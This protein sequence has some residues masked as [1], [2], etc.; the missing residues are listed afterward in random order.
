MIPPDMG[1][2][3]GPN[4]VMLALNSQVRIQDKIG[5]SQHT[6][7][8]N[9]FFRRDGQNYNVFDPKVIFDPYGNR[10]IITAPANSNSDSSVLLIGVSENS[11]PYSSWHINAYKVDPTNKNWFD[12]PS[13]GFNK[14]WIVVTGNIYDIKQEKVPNNFIGPQVYIFDKEALYK[15]TAVPSVA[16]Y[17][18]TFGFTI[19]PAVTYDTVLN[20]MYLISSFNGSEN[21][22]GFLHIYTISGTPSNPGPLLGS[23]Y[24]TSSKTWAEIDDNNESN[25]APQKDT[26]AKIQTGDD[27]I[28][29]A[30]YRNGS[31]WCAHTIFLPTDAPT[32]SGIQWW[33]IN[34]TN[35]NSLQTG[36]IEDTTSQTF[37]AFPSIA[38]DNSNNVL[39]G[40][41]TFS[42]LQY[43]SSAFS[44]HLVTDP[45]NI[46]SQF[47]IF[48]QGIAKYV[49]DFGYGSN[50]WGDYSST[51]LDPD[52]KS[53]WTIQEYA[54]KPNSAECLWGTEWCKV[55]LK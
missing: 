14:N 45:A 30:V 54:E 40:Y 23:F 24:P 10:W 15:G 26:T 22:A 51:V 11:D 47:T 33:Q 53:F 4:N 5:G 43:G 38:V 25:F 44:M 17:N 16:N 41:S 19:T 12:Y 37:Y 42:Y 32:H 1:G 6:I 21:N 28:Q 7:S 52:G 39:I 2:A 3:V 46:T 13:I 9:D 27:R 34:P 8:L 55:W 50:R 18:N 29:N 49:K 31:L 48:K 35:G 36:R 20:I